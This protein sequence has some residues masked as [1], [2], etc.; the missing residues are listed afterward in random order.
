MAPSE[1]K[2]KSCR[3]SRVI[4]HQERKDTQKVGKKGTGETEVNKHVV[5]QGKGE[6][7]KKICGKKEAEK[8]GNAT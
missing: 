8:R 7:K 6:A 1:C 4:C 3:L 5:R 2:S